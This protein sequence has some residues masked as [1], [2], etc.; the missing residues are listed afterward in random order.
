[1]TEQSAKNPDMPD[2]DELS[3]Q[4]F[5][6]GAEILTTK[7]T[8]DE[9]QVQA[10]RTANGIENPTDRR[11]N[12]LLGLIGEIGE[13][14]ANAFSY[15]PSRSIHEEEFDK[16][17]FNVV[18]LGVHAED[19]KHELFH[20][21]PKGHE[22]EKPKLTRENRKEEL[23][24]ILWYLTW[25]CSEFGFSLEEVARSNISKLRARYPD[26]FSVERSINRKER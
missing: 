10:S 12:A 25:M 18:H 15:N 19:M 6:D 5:R 1:M 2:V 24:D 9:Y 4:S 14:A 3:E 26:G 13:F 16:F 8:M 11:F 20:K 23:G 21:H 22:I 7:L 17:L